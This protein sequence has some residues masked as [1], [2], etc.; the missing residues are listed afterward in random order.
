M[1]CPSCSHRLSV[2]DCRNI[3]A[4]FVVWRRRKCPNCNA[5]FHTWESFSPAHENYPTADDFFATFLA[6]NPSKAE[7]MIHAMTQAALRFSAE[8]DRLEPPKDQSQEEILQAIDTLLRQGADDVI[9]KLKLGAA[10]SLAK[11]RMWR[12]RCLI[13]DFAT[14]LS[15]PP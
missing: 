10:S 5:R 11:S 4:D 13:E 3:G 9:E 1:K 7:S 2:V 14:E 12:L 8:L 15:S 6:S